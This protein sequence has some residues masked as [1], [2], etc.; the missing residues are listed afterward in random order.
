MIWLLYNLQVIN[1]RYQKVSNCNLEITFLF[2]VEH[3]IKKNYIKRYEKMSVINITTTMAEVYIKLKQ[4]KFS[5][6]LVILIIEI[7]GGG[8]RERNKLFRVILAAVLCFV[9]LG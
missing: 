6:L 9:F 8:G 3:W 1:R 7:G 4:E 2:F 5:K